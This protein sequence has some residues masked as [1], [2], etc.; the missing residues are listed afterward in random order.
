MKIKA[1]M[2]RSRHASDRSNGQVVVTDRRQEVEEREKLLNR[3]AGWT[4][5]NG[6]RSRYWMGANF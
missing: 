1:G 3:A 5:G 4:K 6:K 2:S